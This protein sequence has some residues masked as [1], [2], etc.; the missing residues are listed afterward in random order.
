MTKQEK[1]SKSHTYKRYTFKSIKEGGYTI[2]SPDNKEVSWGKSIK[3]S[4]VVVNQLIGE[5]Y[6][7]K[8]EALK[9]R[10]FVSSVLKKVA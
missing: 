4:K 9:I 5:W 3:E 8:D 2:C 7:S 10:K 6:P 1:S